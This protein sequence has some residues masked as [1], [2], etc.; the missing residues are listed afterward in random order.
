[1]R[2]YFA[3]GIESPKTG[4]N[5]GSLWR[6]ATIYGA[7]FIFT[8]GRRYKKSAHCGIADT[9]NTPKHTPLLHFDTIEMLRSALYDCP[10]IGV[11]LDPNAV[12]LAAY[13]HPQ[14]ACYLLGSEDNG[15][16]KAALEACHSLVVLPGRFSMNV[17][18]AGSTVLYDRHSKI[19][20]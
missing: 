13:R 11:E 15:L 16:S 9:C 8:V 4:Q 14:R 6:A 1:M 2:N 20:T 19:N 12:P 18:C 7:A 17:A 10:L 3:I 5:V